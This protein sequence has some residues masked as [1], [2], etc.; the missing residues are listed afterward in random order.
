MPEDPR[1]PISRIDGAIKQLQLAR[2][3]LL[4]HDDPRVEDLSAQIAELRELRATLR[5]NSEA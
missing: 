5:A 3:A 1:S 2:E 4:V